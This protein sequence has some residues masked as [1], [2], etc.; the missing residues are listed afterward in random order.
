MFKGV[1]IGILLT[2]LIGT[3]VMAAATP[4]TRQL[5]AI[6]SGISVVL[7]GQR[8]DLRDAAGNVVEPFIV[9]GTTYLPIRAI[10]NALDLSVDWDG[11]TQTVYLG[12]PQIPQQPTP[13]PPPTLEPPTPPPQAPV[14]RGAIGFSE[15]DEDYR[16]SGFIL[17]GVPANFLV[18]GQALPITPN[19]L[20]FQTTN[21]WSN[22]TN[23]VSAQ[24]ALDAGYTR[25]TAQFAVADG[26]GFGG[27]VSFWDLTVT[28]SPREIGSFRKSAGSNP[29]DIDIPLTGVETLMISMGHFGTGRNSVHAVL[30]DGNFT[31]A[32]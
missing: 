20:R 4:V 23:P 27:T 21:T 24:Y 17:T 18:R 9:D 3:T 5:T 26:S 12:S 25:L 1:I 32:N 13:L 2:V 28:G 29:I 14:E 31:P 15:L 16:F 19:G 11:T 7:D 10:A 8:L 30:F 22:Q 6:F